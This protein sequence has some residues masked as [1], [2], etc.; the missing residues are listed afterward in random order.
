MRKKDVEGAKVKAGIM[1][2]ALISQALWETLE[3]VEDG[4]NVLT[5]AGKA[6]DTHKKRKAAIEKANQEVLREDRR[7]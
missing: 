6:L 5:A 3:H 4:D 1:T 2:A 7:R